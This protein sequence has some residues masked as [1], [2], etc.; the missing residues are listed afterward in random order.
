MGTNY[1]KMFIVA[2]VDIRGIGQNELVCILK[3]EF[4]N[5]TENEKSKFQII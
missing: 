2:K 3:N 4:E 1:K 5:L